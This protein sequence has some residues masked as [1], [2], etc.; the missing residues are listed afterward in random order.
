MLERACSGVQ[1]C[2]VGHCSE[3]Q[4]IYGGRFIYQINCGY[5]HWLLAAS[6]TVL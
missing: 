2:R 4:E 1:S 6:A 3:V 5:W